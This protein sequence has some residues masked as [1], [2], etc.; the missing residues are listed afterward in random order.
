M[1][2]ELENMDPAEV[3]KQVEEG[4]KKLKAELKRLDNEFRELKKR[5]KNRLATTEEIEKLREIYADARSV[6]RQAGG[7]ITPDPEK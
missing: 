7:E 1:D 5:V 4:R 2:K 6:L 3:R